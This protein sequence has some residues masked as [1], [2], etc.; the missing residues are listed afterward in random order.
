[1]IPREAAL[2]ASDCRDRSDGQMAR[3][4]LPQPKLKSLPHNWHGQRSAIFHDAY[5]LARRGLTL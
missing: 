5:K 1:M 3:S 4:L 2:D